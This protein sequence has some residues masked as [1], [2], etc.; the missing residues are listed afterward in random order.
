M[1]QVDNDFVQDQDEVLKIKYSLNESLQ[2][3]YG[4]QHLQ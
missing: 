4:D 2:M 1:R 3:Q